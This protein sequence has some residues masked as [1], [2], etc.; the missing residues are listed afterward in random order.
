MPSNSFE[1]KHKRVQSRTKYF[2]EYYKKCLEKNETKCGVEES[3]R[4]E[5]FENSYFTQPKIVLK[6]FSAKKNYIE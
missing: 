6:T 3:F 4:S 1:S 2:L 5:K